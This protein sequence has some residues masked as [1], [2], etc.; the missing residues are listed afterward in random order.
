M[1]RGYIINIFMCYWNLRHVSISYYVVVLVRQHD[2]YIHTCV[3]GRTLVRVLVK[4]GMRWV[5]CQ[6]MS[7]VAI[8][9]LLIIIHGNG[10]ASKNGV[11]W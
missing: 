7:I 8:Q 2:K 5:V 3:T 10:S 9:F 1:M 11:A 6:G 4:N